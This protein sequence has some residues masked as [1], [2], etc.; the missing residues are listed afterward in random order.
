MPRAASSTT[1]TTVVGGRVTVS[2]PKEAAADLTHLKTFFESEIERATNVAVE[3]SHAQVVQT[4]LKKLR[5]FAAETK[6][7]PTPDTAGTADPVAE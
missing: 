6:A 7:A 5:E 3:L 1:D 4:A 2:L